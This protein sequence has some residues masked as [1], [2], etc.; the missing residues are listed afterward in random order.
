MLETSQPW[1]LFGYDLRRGLHYFRA[2]WSDFLWGD[3]SPVLNVIDEVVEVHLEA[4]ETRYYQAGKLVVGPV[5]PGTVKAQAIVLPERLV[6]SRTLRVPVAAEA[7][8]DS[9]LVLEVRASSPFP[10]AD[11]SYGWSIV[12]RRASDLDVQLVITSQSAV[13]A[14]IASQLDCHDIRAYEIWAQSGGRMVSV[15]GF[16]EAKRQQ[17]NRRRFGRIAIAL[18]YC[19]LVVIAAFA[20]GAGA[21]YLELQKVRAIQVRVEQSASEAV[22]LRTGLASSK[23]LIGAVNKLLLEYPAP[24]YELKRLATI[25]GDDTWIMMVEINGSNIKIDG[26]SSDAAAVMQQLLDHSAYVRVVSPVAIRKVGS[27]IERFLLNLTLATEDG[28]E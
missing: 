28:G 14:F 1:N 8:L 10:E 19:L 23:G 12:D 25:L 16:G 26:Q 9:V 15:S 20:L 22:E 27:G 6:L 2:G 5:A 17:R 3:D 24:H 4:G 11:T 7:D 21:K 13:M 18:A